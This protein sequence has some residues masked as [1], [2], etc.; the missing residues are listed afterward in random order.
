MQRGL[1]APPKGGRPT[2]SALLVM[3]AMA[4]Q[5]AAPGCAPSLNTIYVTIE[6]Y[7]SAVS[8]NDLTR[9]L[10][11][12]APY[13]RELAASAT[14]EAKSALAKKYRDIV[15]GGYIGWE[16]AKARGELRPDSLGVGLI[17]AIGLGKEGAASQPL[18]VRFE[19]GNTRAVVRERA[20]TNYDSIRWDSIPTGGRMYLLGHPFG[21]VV[22]FATGYDDPSKLALLATVD[23][24]WTLVRIPGLKRPEGAPSDWYVESIDVLADT[25]TSWSPPAPASD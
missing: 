23:M 13:Q 19:A 4:A 5:L 9:I 17:R 3:M 16:D 25:A 12:C 21:K 15:E 7:I 10:A 20:I 2:L 8:L 1:P 11:M 18:N 14:P 6:T 24:E 22:N